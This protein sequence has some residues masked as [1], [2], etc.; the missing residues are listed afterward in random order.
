LI[1]THE[2]R[3]VRV[4]ASFI[5]RLVGLMG[6]KELESVF[7]WIPDCRSIHTCFMRGPID[8]AFLDDEG[9]VIDR[10]HRLAPWRIRRGAKGSKSVMELPAG[11]L[12]RSDIRIGDR[13]TWA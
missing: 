5:D 11:F 6:K 13:V 7:L 12:K 10:H 1:R 2:I 9:N 8:I 3:A 4:A